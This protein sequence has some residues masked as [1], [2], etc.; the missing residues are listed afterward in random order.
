MDYLIKW[1]VKVIFRTPGTN[2]KRESNHR[3]VSRTCDD[4]RHIPEKKMKKALEKHEGESPNVSVNLS[5][6]E[7]K[8]RKH[9]PL[10]MVIE[11]VRQNL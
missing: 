11:G 10:L 2:Q 8:K 5:F 6:V 9:I 4:V 1:R 7:K 3:L